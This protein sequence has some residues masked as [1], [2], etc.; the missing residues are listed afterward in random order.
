MGHRETRSVVARPIT[1]MRPQAVQ[2]L[3]VRPCCSPGVPM[4]ARLGRA[5][6]LRQ[7][8]AADPRERPRKAKRRRYQSLEEPLRHADRVSTHEPQGFCQQCGAFRERIDKAAQFK[9]A[10]CVV[11]LP[12]QGGRRGGEGG[13][14]SKDKSIK[15]MCQQFSW[16]STGMLA[17]KKTSMDTCRPSRK[18][19]SAPSRMMA[20]ARRRCAAAVA[21][22]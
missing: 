13:V 21:R 1:R 19:A 11:G 6:L 17:P 5:Q 12:L 16:Q 7:A 3:E 14:A 2:L 4:L 9:Q 10:A 15:R 8:A 18:R 22:L 20:S